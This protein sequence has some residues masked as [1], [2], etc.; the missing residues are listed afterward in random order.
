MNTR[1]ADC[2]WTRRAF[3]LIALSWQV[4]AALHPADWILERLTVDDTFLLLRSIQGW[5]EHGVPTFDGIHRTNGFQALWAIVLLPLAA[6]F[7]Q[8]ELLLRATLLL[9]AVVNTA[10]GVVL[11]RWSAVR[12]R[13]PRMALWV[14]AIW[15]GYCVA[16]RPAM[17]GLENCLLGL[18]TA[19]AVTIVGD[20]KSP[21]LLGTI[22]RAA[23]CSAMIWTRLDAL[24][25]AAPLWLATL[26]AGR[27]AI[28]AFALGGLILASGTIG[29]MTFNNWAGGSWTPVSGMVKRD[30][31]A[32]IEPHW[33]IGVVGEALIDSVRQ[34]TKALTI[35][36]GNVWPPALSTATRIIAPILIGIAAWRYRAPGAGWVGLWLIACTAHILGIRLWLGEYHADA[37]WYYSVEGVLGVVAFTWAAARLTGAGRSGAALAIGVGV[38]KLP[39]A[40]LS[41]FLPSLHE[42]VDSNR[43]A[44]ARWI[45]ENVPPNE[46]LASWNAG[47][48]AFFSQRTIINLDGLVNDRAYFALLHAGRAG[49]EYLRENDVRWVVD[50]ASGTAD[51]QAALWGWLRRDDWTLAARFGGRDELAQV[52]YRRVATGH[53]S[54]ATSAPTKATPEAE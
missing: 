23:V 46:R 34:G 54:A 42:T 17:I 43:L 11:F 18:L 44:A 3:L 49:A 41:L 26:R 14:A 12:L 32:Q 38:I 1:A 53:S 21:T 50:Y 39:I 22:A 52:I 15:C 45:R 8:P 16:A 9:A 51:E 2:V 48:L 31:A 30:I 25:I 4:A 37:L 19:I 33:S 24:L 13:D 40:L 10:T 28:P 5:A 36:V 29:L 27:R 6:C 47:E 7:P 20:P 35:G